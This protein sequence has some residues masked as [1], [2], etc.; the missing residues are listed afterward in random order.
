MIRPKVSA[1]DGSTSI[2]GDNNAPVVNINAG[3]SSTVTVQV[4]R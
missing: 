2:G 3:D 4:E 1:D